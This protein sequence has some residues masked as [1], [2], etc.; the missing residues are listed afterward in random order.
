MDANK[1]DRFDVLIS[2]PLKR[3]DPYEVLFGLTH[4]LTLQ[5][6]WEFLSNSGEW[7]FKFVAHG[8]HD[9]VFMTGWV[10]HELCHQVEEVK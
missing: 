2:N 1:T 3:N 10:S 4:N 6:V 8:N 5:K 9:V 7:N